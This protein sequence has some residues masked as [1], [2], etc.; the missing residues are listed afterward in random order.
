MIDIKMVSNPDLDRFIE[1]L[2]QGLN[3]ISYQLDQQGDMTEDIWCCIQNTIKILDQIV[4][5]IRID[6]SK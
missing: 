2:I 1:N 3:D 4:E 6:K 5:F